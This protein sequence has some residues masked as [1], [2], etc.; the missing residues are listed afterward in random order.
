VL[1]G[2]GRPER[3]KQKLAE[4]GFSSMLFALSGSNPLGLRNKM[5]GLA[6]AWHV[7]SLQLPTARTL[8]AA[9]NLQSTI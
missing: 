8:G 1:N 5:I 3:N 9:A 2:A 7:A 6:S 4:A